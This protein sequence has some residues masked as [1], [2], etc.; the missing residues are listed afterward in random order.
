MRKARR[1]FCSKCLGLFRGS[2]EEAITE[3]A[4]RCDGVL[5]C[6]GETPSS[7]GE[8]LEDFRTRAL[9]DRRTK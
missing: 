2:L 7:L 6:R 8:L 1:F 3:H 4:R 5:E 9:H